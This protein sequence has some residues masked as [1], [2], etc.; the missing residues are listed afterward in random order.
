ME[1]KTT[2]KKRGLAA[3][4]ALCPLRHAVAALS[5]LVIGL[6]LATRAITP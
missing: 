6:H 1:N 3:I 4:F 2:V 5:A